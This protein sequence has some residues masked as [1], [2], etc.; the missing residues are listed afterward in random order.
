MSA[1][2][3]TLAKLV[4]LPIALALALA[5]CASTPAQT[6]VAIAP[7]VSTQGGPTPSIATPSTASA[8]ELALKTY[9]MATVKKHKTRSSCWTVVG[10][11][12][13]NLTKWI[14]KHPGGSKRILAMCGKNATKAFRAQHGS[15]GKAAKTLATYKIG[16]LA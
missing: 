15:T 11:G 16:K 13:Y 7:A 4:F 10:T 5:A 12:V 6:P 1:H 14:S 8:D 3:T 2:L 9:T